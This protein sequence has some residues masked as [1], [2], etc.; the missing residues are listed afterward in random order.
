MK[1]TVLMTNAGTIR[2][3][4]T[5]LR[6]LAFAECLTN[7]GWDVHY[8]LAFREEDFRTYGEQHNG[9]RLHYTHD[10][11]VV[12]EI[13]WPWDELD[14]MR[15]VGHN[16]R[17]RSRA[18]RD[19]EPDV[20]HVFKPHPHSLIPPVLTC[21]PAIPVIVDVDDAETDMLKRNFPRMS[22]WFLKLSRF[23]EDN[24]F[25][26]ADHVVT[27]SRAFEEFFHEKRAQVS[28]IPNG[29]F[30]EDS[31]PAVVPE[32]KVLGNRTVFGYMGNLHPCF[33]VE[34]VLKV[35]RQVMQHVPQSVLMIIGEGPEEERIRRMA[36]HLGI[37][38]QV[39][40]TGFVPKKDIPAYLRTADVLL[41]PMVDNR[42]NKFRC[43]L[44]IREY[45]A[46]GKPIVASNVGEAAEALG[47]REMLVGPDEGE[48]GFVLRIQRLLSRPEYAQTKARQNR[49]RGECFTWQKLTER[50]IE[51]YE[52]LCSAGETHPQLSLVE[53]QR[54]HM[55]ISTRVDDAEDASGRLAG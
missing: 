14:V 7:M 51:V 2:G 44:K 47:D 6:S 19:I 50:L 43:P 5:S 22:R 11:P 4:S 1:K 13:R 40:I 37:E 12:R 23:L 30:C 38:S 36:R 28:Y 26:Y 27:V 53:Q 33:E 17:E 10:L 42:L 34:L 32:L 15:H 52:R 9:I 49:I 39:L 24:C 48:D 8:L 55:D 20:V 3:F 29:V 45:L 25:R 21:D 35:Y 31:D 18:I 41:F 54:V 16:I 46:A